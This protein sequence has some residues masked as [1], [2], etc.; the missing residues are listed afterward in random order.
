MELK[1]SV[2]EGIELIKEVEKEFTI[3][4][5]VPGICHI[6]NWVD[7]V[8]YD[9][10]VFCVSQLLDNHVGQHNNQD[11]AAGCPFFSDIDGAIPH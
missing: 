11:V 2:L 3:M 10:R 8:F 6:T 9:L 1:A 4:L 5:T 7:L